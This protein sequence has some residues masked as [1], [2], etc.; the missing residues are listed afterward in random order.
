MLIGDASKPKT[1]LGWESK[2]K[3]DELVKVMARADYDKVRKR[4]F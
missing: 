4:G 3:F 2:I 1:E